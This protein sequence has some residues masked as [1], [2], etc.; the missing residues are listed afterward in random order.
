LADPVI[1]AYLLSL[2]QP[3]MTAAKRRGEL[4]PEMEEAYAWQIFAM[5][6]KSVNAFALPGG[7]FGVHLG[8]LA[9]V[10]TPDEL[11]SVLAHELTH[12]TQRHIARGFSRQNA[13]SPL[14]LAG[15]LLAILAATRANN[16]NSNAAAQGAL[17]ATQAVGI[18]SRLN[19]SRDMEREAD[20][21]GFTLM[22][23]A[24]YEP[25]A[26]VAMFNKLALAARLND[27][28]NFPYLRSHPL[29]T[30]RIADMSARVGS[31][32]TAGPTQAT[33]EQL[34]IHRLMAVRAK[35][36]ADPSV[37]AL[38]S[39]IQ[40]ARQAYQAPEQLAAANLMPALYGGALAAGRLK[41]GALARQL[42]SELQLQAKRSNPG[43]LALQ[44]VRWLA[45]DLRLESA[46]TPRLDINSSNRIELLY[47][48]EA[49]LRSNTSPEAQ[50]IAMQK[51]T[52]WVSA[53]PQ[54]AQAWELLAQ[55]QLAQKQSGPQNQNIR[56]A[57][58][59]GRSARARYND[60]G[61]LAHFMAAQNLIRQQAPGEVDRI[62]AAIVDSQVREL[63]RRIRE[64]T[65][66][67]GLP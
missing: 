51:L 26:F 34:A 28:G 58:S 18:Q 10:D 16:A 29:T 20:R 57:M 48:A 13:Q 56:A 2:W 5:R 35:V 44:A 15:T 6:D 64:Q 61:A 1:D 17:A 21:I 24:G 67:A 7:F 53:R 38:T 30:E 49:A 8:L 36:L 32:P 63:Q 60:P 11:A 33:P 25:G 9:L 12:A 55:L 52:L 62:D 3:L 4:A 41:D 19:F 45:A 31:T 42:Y 39:H 66:Q 47:A 54:D 46:M 43:E 14:L 50:T 22:A 37:A 23:D 65:A 40:Q 27:S 59:L